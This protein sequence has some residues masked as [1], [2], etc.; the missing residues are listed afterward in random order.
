M[1]VITPLQALVHPQTQKNYPAWIVK[2]QP[3][4]LTIRFFCKK[5]KKKKKDLQIRN[6]GFQSSKQLMS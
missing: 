6:C 2:P 3:Q 1:P 5:K 4:F